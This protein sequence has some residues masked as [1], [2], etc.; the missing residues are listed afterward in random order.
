MVGLVLLDIQTLFLRGFID[1]SQQVSEGIGAVNARLPDAQHIQVGAVE[2]ENFHLS[3]SI[4]WARVAS[5]APSLSIS[6][7]AKA[8]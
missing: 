6:A 3:S 5:S 4:I 8:A 2:N 1:Q 7:S